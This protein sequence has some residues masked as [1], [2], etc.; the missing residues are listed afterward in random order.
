MIDRR[1]YYVLAA[2]Q[3]QTHTSTDIAA[4]AHALGAPPAGATHAW[5]Y[6]DRLVC[7]GALVRERQLRLD[8]K[9]E[10]ALYMVTP[11]GDAMIAAMAERFAS[12]AKAAGRLK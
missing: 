11:K 3:S 8:G 12:M 5:T 9:A 4:I 6:L 1:C 2:K 7:E 10:K